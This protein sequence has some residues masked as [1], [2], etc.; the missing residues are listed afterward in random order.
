MITQLSIYDTLKIKKGCK[1]I[2]RFLWLKAFKQVNIE[3]T[4]CGNGEFYYRKFVF[5]P[6][7]IEPENNVTTS[8]EQVSKTV[9]K[10]QKLKEKKDTAEKQV[11]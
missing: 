3:S 6:D 9:V 7:G 4:F 2:G 8:N 1:G 10:K 5:S 11:K